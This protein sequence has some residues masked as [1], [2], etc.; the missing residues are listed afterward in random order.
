MSKSKAVQVINN[1]RPPKKAGIH[2]RLLCLTG[3]NKGVSFYIK[4]KR[5]VL[6]RGVSADVQV[7]DEKASRE[8][9]E[10]VRVGENFILT[11]LK[12]Q[13][14][15]VVEDLKVTQHKLSSGDKIIIGASVYKFEVFENEESSGLEVF[16]EPEEDQ[17]ESEKD[18]SEA[19]KKP[20]YYIYFWRR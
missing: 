1:F 14:G 12:S 19:P 3:A 9:A 11:D 5:I 4:E 18:K 8:H 7:L 13:N 15:T 16:E 2:H 6:G 17:K 20:N 10:I